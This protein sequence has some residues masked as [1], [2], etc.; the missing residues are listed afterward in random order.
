[1]CADYRQLN[2]QMVKEQ[3]PLP[4]IDEIFSHL[5]SAHGLLSLDLR[6][7]YDPIPDRIEYRPK[8]AFI[9]QKGVFV[10]KVIPFRL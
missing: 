4:C 3:Y 6:M 9:T 10:F 5:H 2:K 1:M 8:T 7:G